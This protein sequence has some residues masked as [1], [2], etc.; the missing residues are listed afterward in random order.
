MP[1]LLPAF[2]PLLIAPL[3]LPQA[4]H[5]YATPPPAIE[6]VGRQGELQRAL[7]SLE[8]WRYVEVRGPPGEGKSTLVQHA[9]QA[10]C[11]QWQ[12]LPK[13][14]AAGKAAYALEVDLR[15][16]PWGRYGFRRGAAGR[17]LACGVL[18]AVP[19]P[20][21]ISSGVLCTYL[22]SSHSMLFGCD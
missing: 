4:M 1:V 5:N 3:P 10:L 11:G 6:M 9:V 20:D 16:A 8:Q 22:Q 2:W 18:L 21:D 7:Q 13:V 12:A 19:L 17:A 15:G 14:Q